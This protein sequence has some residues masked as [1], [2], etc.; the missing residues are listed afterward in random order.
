LNIVQTVNIEGE[1][2]RDTYLYGDRSRDSILR[3]VPE[4]TTVI[5]LYN[6]EA[7][8]NLCQVRMADGTVGWMDWSDYLVSRENYTQSRDYSETVKTAFVNQRGYSSPTG[9]LIWLNLK[10]QKVNIFQGSQGNW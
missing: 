7:A 6:P 5:H 9:Y 8:D 2:L 10:T 3:T 1:T 4:G